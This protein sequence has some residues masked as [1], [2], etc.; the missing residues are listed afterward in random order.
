MLLSF[1]AMS[2]PGGGGQGSGGFA[3]FLPMI[4]IFVIFYFL[5]LRPQ[6]KKQRLHQSMLQSLNKG[7]KIV[8]T[9]GVHGTILRVDE[10]NK[11]M[12]VKVADDTKLTID[13]GAVARKIDGSG[14]D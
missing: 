8:T 14:R 4:L 12:L 10:S 1:L 11:T 6:A 9:G 5:I 3:A 2:Q 13:T 7:D